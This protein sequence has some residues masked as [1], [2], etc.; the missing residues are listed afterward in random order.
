MAKIKKSISLLPTL[1][2]EANF[3]EDSI[4]IPFTLSVG[5]EP[6]WVVVTQPSERQLTQVCWTSKSNLSSTTKWDYFHGN[7]SY[8]FGDP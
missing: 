4:L 2:S 6:S 5:W 7:D 3:Y 1:G 8:E